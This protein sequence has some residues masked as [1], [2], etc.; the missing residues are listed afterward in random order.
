MSLD[1]SYCFI[2]HNYNE[3]TA[4]S[5]L[6]VSRKVE[7]DAVL[8]VTFTRRKQHCQLNIIF[9]YE[10]KNSLFLWYEL[11]VF[12]AKLAMF[13][14]IEK[15]LFKI[16]CIF[17]NPSLCLI[18]IIFQKFQDKFANYLENNT[19]YGLTHEI[20]II[21]FAAMKSSFE[22]LLLKLVHNAI[23]FLLLYLCRSTFSAFFSS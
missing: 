10:N 6:W 20:L 4:L 3:N 15:N 21:P 22:T 16:N 11:D 17:K 12:D 14:I 13:V 19:L 9:D 5:N 2:M 23:L 8:R 7:G 18:C 1:F